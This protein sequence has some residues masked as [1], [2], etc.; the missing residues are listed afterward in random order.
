MKNASE[1]MMIARIYLP[2]FEFLSPKLVMPLG[3]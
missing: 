1:Y 2:Y 3:R